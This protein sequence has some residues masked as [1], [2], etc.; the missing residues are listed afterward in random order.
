MEAARI[1]QEKFGDAKGRIPATFQIVYA[2]G[3]SP[4]DSQQKPLKPGTAQA[5][6]ADALKTEEKSAGDKAQP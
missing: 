4:H 3:W 5:R 1:Y 2:I 6:L